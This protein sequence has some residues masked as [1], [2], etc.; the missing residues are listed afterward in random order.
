[1]AGINYLEGSIYHMV[2]YDNLANI[3]RRRALLSKEKVLDE[4]IAYRSIA[5][6][7]VQ[8]LRDRIFI[9][10]VS[11]RLAKPLHS[12]VPF[13]FA[14][15]PPMLHNMFKRGIQDE[16]VIFE[17]S[18]SILQDPGV[19]FT[20]GNATKQQLAKYGK[21]KVFILP[22]TAASPS[23]KRRYYPI[24][25]HH[26]ANSGCSELFA[27]VALLDHL[28]WEGINNRRYIESRDEYVRI[29]HAEV[30]VPDMVPHKSRARYLC[31]DARNGRSCKCH[32]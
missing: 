21:E 2:H 30:L 8:G 15:Q 5:N 7:E 18:R 17:V 11:K 6:D 26:Q 12:Y 16:I 25:S 19:L 20:N 29:R 4:K 31:Q 1:M 28:D 14:T 27:D 9:W 23:C 3:F 13:Y 10:D 22:A 32:Y 24:D